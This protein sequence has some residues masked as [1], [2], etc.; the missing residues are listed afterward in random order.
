MNPPKI[1]RPRSIG[2]F[3]LLAWLSFVLSVCYLIL[4]VLL[5][6]D[7]PLSANSD[8]PTDL[9]VF[10]AIYGLLSLLS[11]PAVI[12]AA[13]RRRQNWARWLFA[14][15]VALCIV[16]TPAAVLLPSYTFTWVELVF[17][18]LI[19][20]AQIAAVCFAFSRQSAA[21]FKPPGPGGLPDQALAGS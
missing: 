14:V 18:V 10:I 16:M 19:F 6:L 15:L 21:W 5:Y 11:T 7:D 8:D 4:Y 9:E 2:R 12:F 20:V 13:A 17:S 3:E 1:S